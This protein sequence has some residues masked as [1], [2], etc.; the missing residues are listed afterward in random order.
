MPRVTAV[1][2]FVAG[3]ADGG[4]AEGRVDPAAVAKWCRRNKYPLL[5]LAAVAPADGL[6]RREFHAP[7]RLRSIG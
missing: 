6:A 5:A 2:R 4:R 1:V 7:P 3:L